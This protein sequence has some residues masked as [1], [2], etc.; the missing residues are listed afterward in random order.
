MLGSDIEN[1]LNV[2]PNVT[3]KCEICGIPKARK[4]EHDC[5]Q[6]LKNSIEEADQ[7]CNQT[8]K[9]LGMDYET[10]KPFCAR[11]HRMFR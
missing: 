5:F 7:K 1:H 6:Q 10:L 4:A 9:Q 11:K 3:Q 8:E 2:C